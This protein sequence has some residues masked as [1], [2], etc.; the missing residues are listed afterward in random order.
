VIRRQNADVIALQECVNRFDAEWLAQELGMDMRYG[1]GNHRWSEVWLSRLG[2]ESAENYRI[3]ALFHGLL[4]IQVTWDGVPLRLFTTHLRSIGPESRMGVEAR[5][6]TEEVRQILGVLQGVNGPHLLCGDFNAAR[7]GE[8]IPDPVP[9]DHYPARLKEGAGRYYHVPYAR[10]PIQVMLDAGYADCYRDVDPKRARRGRE[11]RVDFIFA[12]A[13][14][15]RRLRES[16]IDRG[17]ATA[18]ASDHPP[19]WAEFS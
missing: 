7:P 3:A 1:Q 2:I 14:L 18:I 12:S 5:R 9:P 10:Q 15:A 6:R 13:A 17:P 19:I 16:G 4:E 11:G 8:F